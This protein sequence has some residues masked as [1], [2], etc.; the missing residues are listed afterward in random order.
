MVTFGLKIKMIFVFVI[1][2][3]M[4]KN[5]DGINTK[6]KELIT[7]ANDKNNNN[8]LLG[9][10]GSVEVRL[11]KEGKAWHIQ[12]EGLGGLIIKD[13]LT[14]G[15]YAFNKKTVSRLEGHFVTCAGE[16]FKRDIDHTYEYIKGFDYL[17]QVPDFG[18]FDRIRETQKEVT[19]TPH[20]DFGNY[21]DIK[22]TI[23][24]KVYGQYNLDLNFKIN[25]KFCRGF[26]GELAY[27]EIGTVNKTLVITKN[28]FNKTIGGSVSD[29]VQNFVES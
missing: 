26:V 17:C 4:S 5:V 13:R 18:L 24:R 9:G 15:S 22:G 8:V 20:E 10:I 12:I 7:W 14:N 21:I 6:I 23:A 29:Y 25:P 11:I 2:K 19:F 28:E 16:D 1:L 3:I 27:G